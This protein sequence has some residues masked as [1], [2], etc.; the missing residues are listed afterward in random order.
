[1]DFDEFINRISSHVDEYT[2][3]RT[4]ALMEALRPYNA[5]RAVCELLGS[6]LRDES[7][8]E[9]IAR[10]SYEHPNGFVKIVLMSTRQ[11][12][13]RLHVWRQGTG[14]GTELENIHNHRWDFASTILVGGYRY[15]EFV[16]TD[17]GKSFFAY[18]YGSQRNASSYSL[19]PYGKR[20]L[21]HSF[22][23]YL[24]AGTSY[25]LRSQ[26]FHR[27]IADPCQTT[28]TLVLHGPK[29]DVPV[30][31]FADS[32]LDSG[33]GLPLKRLPVALLGEHIRDLIGTLEEA[34]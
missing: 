25:T 3:G 6:I 23:A 16:D 12:Q 11:F 22:D 7:W 30:E 28:A 31:V 4:D 9:D 19:L 14:I 5:T 27:I 21:E 20:T 24:R 2:A 18:T 15:Q 17:G 29:M 33:P 8:L 26:A 10:R 13:L 32:M 1:M 34:A